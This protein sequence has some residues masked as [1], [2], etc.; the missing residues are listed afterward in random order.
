M[1]L[2]APRLGEAMVVGSDSASMFSLCGAALLLAP[3]SL[4]WLSKKASMIE[5]APALPRHPGIFTRGGTDK[6]AVPWTGPLL[7]RASDLEGV[8]RGWAVAVTAMPSE[9]VGGSGTAGRW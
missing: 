5:C 9:G 7:L 1:A 4:G 2:L 3:A 6:G 8:G